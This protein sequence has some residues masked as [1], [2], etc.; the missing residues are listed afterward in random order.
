MIVPTNQQFYNFLNKACKLTLWEIATNFRTYIL[1]VLYMLWIPDHVCFLLFTNKNPYLTYTTSLVKRRLDLI[2]RGT[3]H[4]GSVISSRISTLSLM[5]HKAVQCTRVLW[6]FFLNDH[7]A[8]LN[9]G[10]EWVWVSAHHKKLF[11]QP[12]TSHAIVDVKIKEAIFEP[13]GS[14]SWKAT[15]QGF[16]IWGCQLTLWRLTEQ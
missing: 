15:A 16:G 6:F 1:V 4:V 7:E 8:R 10:D 11:A 14:S 9:N 12:S 13:W 5:N 3:V 2:P